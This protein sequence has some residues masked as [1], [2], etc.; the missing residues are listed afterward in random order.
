MNIALVDDSLPFDGWS[1]ASHPLDG[2]ERAFAALAGALARRGHRV[3]AFNRSRLKATID[4]AEWP[5]WDGERPAETD[6]LIAFRRAELLDFIP[7]ARRR[8]LWTSEPAARLDASPARELVGRHRP[9]VVLFS[10][11]QRDAW[12]NPLS[13]DL[14]VIPPGVG[15]SFLDE[16]AMAP[17]APPRA[18]ATCHPEAG[19]DWLLGLWVERIRPAAPAAELHVYSTWLDKGRLGAA[20]PPAIAPALGRAMAASDKGVVIRRPEGEAGMAEAYRAARVHLHPGAP[21]E[22]Y[23]ATLADSQAVGLPGV[24][25]AI[26]PA[27]VERIYAGQS[28]AV[29]P[30]D[31]RFAAV[32][33]DLLCEDAGFARMSAMARQAQRARS[34]DIAA[35]EWEAALP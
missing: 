8:I 5:T 29:A 21:H 2:P 6:A 26:S 20:V 13:L 33:V 4:G 9:L 10:I 18:I 1:P 23:V 25:R 28:G 32:A 7:A 15:A 22:T 11:A 14:R 16:A 24:V 12:S 19:L 35:A 17:A 27:A 30:D 3:L 34:W 31:E